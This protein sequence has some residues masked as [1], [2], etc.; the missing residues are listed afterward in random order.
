MVRSLIVSALV[1][2]FSN[3]ASDLEANDNL[4]GGQCNTP[5][6]THYRCRQ[7]GQITYY[8]PRCCPP[9]NDCRTANYA[10]S[11]S[12]PVTSS[13]YQPVAG[14]PAY[15]IR[16]NYTPY[17]LGQTVSK[18]GWRSWMANPFGA[19]VPASR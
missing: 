14:G 2:I 4:V 8:G 13:T 17:Q 15:N 19:P 10:P 1:V 3:T 12:T 11:E 6:V 5:K 16:S 7:T 18:R 9:V